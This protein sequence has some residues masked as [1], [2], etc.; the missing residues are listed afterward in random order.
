MGDEQL[1]VNSRSRGVSTARLGLSSQPGKG[2][3]AASSS[4]CTRPPHARAS[5]LQAGTPFPMAW[6]MSSS[7]AQVS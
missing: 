6:V 1:E 2:P 7:P 4:Q 3:L 5:V